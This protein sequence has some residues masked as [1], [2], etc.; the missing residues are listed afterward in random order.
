M[1]IV[2]AGIHDADLDAGP[3]QSALLR[4]IRSRHDQRV[5]EVGTRRL[6]RGKCHRHDRKYRR[7]RPKTP[8]V[9]NRLTRRVDRQPPEQSAEYVPFRKNAMPSARAWLRNVSTAPFS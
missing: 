9:S 5:C 1:L 6:D 8:Y 3:G 2:D 7:Y 4:E